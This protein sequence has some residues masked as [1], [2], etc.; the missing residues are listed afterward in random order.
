MHSLGSIGQQQVLLPTVLQPCGRRASAHVL[1]CVTCVLCSVLR[2]FICLLPV[3]V[4]MCSGPIIFTLDGNDEMLQNYVDGVFRMGE[5]PDRNYTKEEMALGLNWSKHVSR[6]RAHS[7]CCNADLGT[8]SPFSR[9]VGRDG[10]CTLLAVACALLS[11]LHLSIRARCLLLLP[12][13]AA[14]DSSESR[15]A[16]HRLR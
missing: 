7:G 14:V 16:V 4:C 3:C 5:S 2:L 11:D 6:V 8:E 15:G 12:L 1:L 9:V 13:H 10:V